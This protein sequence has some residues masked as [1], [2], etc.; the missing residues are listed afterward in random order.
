MFLG[1]VNFLVHKGVATK[2][3]VGTTQRRRMAIVRFVVTWEQLLDTFTGK[4][5]IPQ[6]EELL[7]CPVRTWCLRLSTP[8]EVQVIA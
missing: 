5:R 8:T 7:G 2:E 3:A 1:I 4:N 6:A